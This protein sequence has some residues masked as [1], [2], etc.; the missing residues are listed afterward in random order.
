MVS[1]NSFWSPFIG[2]TLL[3][4]IRN[5]CMS[6]MSC[7]CVGIA[8]AEVWCV[9]IYICRC[10]VCVCVCVDGGKQIGLSSWFWALL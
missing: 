10:C 7:S 3:N 6:C 8:N 9:C 5:I 2:V 4:W 1:R